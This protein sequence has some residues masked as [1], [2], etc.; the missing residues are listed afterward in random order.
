MSRRLYLDL[1]GVLADFDAAFPSVFGIDRSNVSVI[2]LRKGWK[3]VS[4]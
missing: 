3:H 1:D 2:V 4:D